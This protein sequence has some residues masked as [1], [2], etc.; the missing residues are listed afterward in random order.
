MEYIVPD[1]DLN[2][3]LIL[4]KI[5]VTMMKSAEETELSHKYKQTYIKPQ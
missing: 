3:F 1:R 5:G 2:V 4:M